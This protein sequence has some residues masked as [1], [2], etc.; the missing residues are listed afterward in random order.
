MH[1]PSEFGPVTFDD[2]SD[3]PK[4]PW[5]GSMHRM[6]T[7]TT[8]ASIGWYDADGVRHDHSRT[9]PLGDDDG[10][11]IAAAWAE[12]DREFLSADGEPLADAPLF[13][14]LSPEQRRQYN[15]LWG[16]PRA[17][18]LSEDGS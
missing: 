2:V 15:R 7:P 3:L 8:E 1:K 10:D 12:L 6:G 14:L 16:R 5:H 13:A 4:G 17:T 9:L 11:Q 18:H